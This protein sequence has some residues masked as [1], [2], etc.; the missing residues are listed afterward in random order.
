MEKEAK[1]FGYEPR[2]LLR[3]NWLNT[4]CLRFNI[5]N[6]DDLL[7]AIGYGGITLSSV[8]AKLI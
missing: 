4:V 8:I 6:S 2:E 1:K 3:D 7:A 5:N